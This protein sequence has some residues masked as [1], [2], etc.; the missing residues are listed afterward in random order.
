MCLSGSAA[1]KCCV[2]VSLPPG[3]RQPFPG[4]TSQGVHEACQVYLDEMW[5][6]GGSGSQSYKQ[7]LLM[8]QDCQNQRALQGPRP[9][10]GPFGDREMASPVFP[11]TVIVNL[12]GYSIRTLAEKKDLQE[13]ACLPEISHYFVYLF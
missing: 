5:G 1:W 8:R 11:Q 9:H 10:T 12:I 4:L 3:S 7:S 2:P 13:I 6:T